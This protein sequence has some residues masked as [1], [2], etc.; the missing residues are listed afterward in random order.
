M[1]S[2]EFAESELIL[3]KTADNLRY[4]IIG[5]SIL[6]SILG[7]IISIYMGN[8]I[9]KPVV[10]LRNVINRVSRGELAKS[11]LRVSQNEIGKMI[12]SVDIL[13]ESLKQKHN[14][15]TR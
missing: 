14:L 15:Q 5:L 9:T 8:L 4:S 10:Q 7:V 3:S 11:D 13:T 1:K 2:K 12:Q 6:F